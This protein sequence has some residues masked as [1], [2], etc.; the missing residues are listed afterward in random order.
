M[1]VVGEFAL[2][3]SRI[4]WWLDERGID[5]VIASLVRRVQVLGVGV[6]GLQTG[7]VSR[8]LVLAIGGTGA[9]VVFLL[10]AR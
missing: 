9:F 7:L 10:V 1:F 8:E 5:G 6:R 2:T 4:V 3:V